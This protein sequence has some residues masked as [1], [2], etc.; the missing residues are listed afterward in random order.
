[1]TSPDSDEDLA[2]L[3]KG[4]KPRPM[5]KWLTFLLLLVLCGG[6]YYFYK[7]R[8]KSENEGPNYVTQPIH[9]GDVSVTISATG[10]LEPTNQVTV[11]SE[12]SGTALEVFVDSNAQVKKGDPLARLDT[13]KLTQQTERTR[14]SLLASKARVSQAKATVRESTANLERFNELHRLSNG[15]TPSKAELETARA[16]TDRAGADLESAEAAVAEAE[17]DVKSNES[18]L[19]KAIIRSPVDGTVLTRSLDPGQTVAASFQAPELFVIAE[20]LSKM[21]LV[22][23]VAEADIGKVEKAQTA[24]FTVDAWPDRTY[25]ANVTKVSFGS[26][27]LDNVVTYEAELAVANDDLSLRP[28]MTATADIEVGSS[29]GVLVVPTAAL[30]FTPPK[31]PIGESG[32]GKK[33]SFLQNLMPGPGRFRGDRKPV[34]EQAAKRP[35]EGTVWILVNGKPKAIDV[36]VGLSDGKHTEVASDALH[37]GSVV[38]LRQATNTGDS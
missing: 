20:D 6:G 37:E 3:V 28:G 13:S 31:A 38:I 10:N 4:G 25:A 8:Q 32:G 11:G 35:G 12:L 30:R 26:T 19:A 22:V 33:S 34:G 27:I 1:M 24:A 21:D 29:K 17:A 9:R 16:T 7:S 36:K 23:A 15:R 2:T 5:R 14:A 18:D